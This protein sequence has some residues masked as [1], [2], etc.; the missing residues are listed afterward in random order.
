MTPTANTSEISY[1]VDYIDNST[2]GP[3]TI[4]A[5][6]R[7]SNVWSNDTN[8]S[9]TTTTNTTGEISPRSNRYCM[10]VP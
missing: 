6:D 4:K 2:P 9:L 3:V 8:T 10:D 5:N 1:N 7:V